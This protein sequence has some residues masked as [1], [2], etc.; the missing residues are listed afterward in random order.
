MK[1]IRTQRGPRQRVILNLGNCLDLPKEKWPDLALRIEE[2]IGGTKT[3]IPFEVEVEALA[4]KFARQAIKKQSQPVISS[5]EEQTEVPDF[6]TVDLN[7]MKQEVV[8]SIGAEHLLFSTLK[9]L[10]LDKILS[11]LG[12][13][14]REMELAIGRLVSRAIFPGSEKRHWKKSKP[15][16]V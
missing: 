5:P 7:S 2:L 6:Q 8:R 11:Q 16:V 1:S 10:E 12:L 3:L 9:E 15:V 13:N 14:R 4:Q